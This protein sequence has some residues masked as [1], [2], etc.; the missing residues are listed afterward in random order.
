MSFVLHPEYLIPLLTPSFLPSRSSRKS[1]QHPSSSPNPTPGVLSTS[2]FPLFWGFFPRAGCQINFLKAS[3][4]YTSPPSSQRF[5]V[6]PLPVEWCPSILV[7]LPC[8]EP[9]SRFKRFSHHSLYTARCWPQW[10]I[11]HFEPKWAVRVSSCYVFFFFWSR[12][13]FF[14]NCNANLSFFLTQTL[15]LT[16]TLYF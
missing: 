4:Y 2:H 7:T 15:H 5:N 13:S 6:S 14:S 16:W 8:S 9:N 12:L 10:T 3:T 1:L 11:S